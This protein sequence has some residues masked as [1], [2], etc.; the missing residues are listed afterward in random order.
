MFTERTRDYFDNAKIGGAKMKKIY[1]K[2]F[3]EV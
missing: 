2:C 3:A 1:F